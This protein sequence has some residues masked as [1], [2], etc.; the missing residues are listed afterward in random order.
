[1]PSELIWATRGHVGGSI[2]EAKYKPNG[3]TGVKRPSPKMS[4]GGAMPFLAK[5]MPWNQM[6][7]IGPPADL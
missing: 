3:L 6:E 4:Q 7:G 2:W 5:T 1:M